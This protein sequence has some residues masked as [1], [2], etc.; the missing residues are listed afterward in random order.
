MESNHKLKKSLILNQILPK[1]FER[2]WQ[3]SKDYISLVKNNYH[4]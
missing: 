1:K 3:I 4:H 2:Q